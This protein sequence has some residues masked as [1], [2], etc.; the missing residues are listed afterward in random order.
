MLTQEFLSQEILDLAG[1]SYEAKAQ[2]VYLGLRYLAEAV[3]LLARQPDDA[4]LQNS[5]LGQEIRQL[6]PEITADFVWQAP[7]HDNDFLNLMDKPLSALGLA[8][9]WP[10]YFHH[11]GFHYVGSFLLGLTRE[12]LLIFSKKGFEGLPRLRPAMIPPRDW[13]A[14]P[15]FPPEWIRELR[16]LRDGLLSGLRRQQ[17]EKTGEVLVTALWTPGGL[18]GW[19]YEKYVMSE[20]YV[21]PEMACS[22]SQIK[23]L[24]QLVRMRNPQLLLKLTCLDQARIDFITERLKQL[25]L[26][27]GMRRKKYL[28]FLR[29]NNIPLPFSEQGPI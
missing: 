17:S 12:N 2:A 5:P 3:H 16:M 14:P 4:D 28:R 26:S 10:D 19:A 6:A 23:Y 21:W 27:F 25:G 20:N 22:D 13:E 8:G 11:R 9:R 29:E 18:S 7:Y 1:L 15:R 24:W